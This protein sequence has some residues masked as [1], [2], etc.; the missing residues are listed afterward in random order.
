MK[1]FF[2]RR[3]VPA[4]AALACIAGL[5][6]TARAAGDPALVAR[7]AYLAT[8]ADCVAC[9]TVP[10]QQ[11]FTGG[12][13]FSLPFGTLYSTNITPDTETG[14]G[15]WTDDDFVRA[16]HEGI[17]KGGVHLYPAFPYASFTGMSREDALAIKA[18]LFSLPPVHSPAPENKIAFPFNL[19]F[20]MAAWNMLYNPDKRFTPDPA[21]SAEWNRG[22]YLVNVLGHC[23]ECH[24]PRTLAFGLDQ[25]RPLAGTVVDGWK[26]YN[27]TPDKQ[28]GIGGWTDEAL[29]Q[30]LAT[31][32]AEGH[33]VASGPMAEAIED[34]LRHLTPQDIHAMVVYLKSVPPQPGG[35]GP[36]V[37]TD[38]PALAQTV[39]FGP[40]PAAS[41][42]DLGRHIFE[43]SCASCHSWDGTGLQTPYAGLRGDR[44][45]NDP[46]ATNVVQIVLQGANLHTAAGVV[47]MPSFANA[48]TDAEIAAVANYVVGRFGGTPA[49]VT[50]A[51]VARA[52]AGTPPPPWLP[53]VLPAIV[54]A[55][56]L[57]LLAVVLALTPRRRIA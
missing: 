27:I 31:G 29:A 53:Y 3:V 8:A 35:T 57:A 7:G 18:Y 19:R 30:F 50:A 51:D 39:A 34:S 5:A 52:R 46:D 4:F 13:A 54:L 11:R 12:R 22:S 47:T 36:V 1:R 44:S 25:S 33:G 28:S 14:I 9:H 2:A 38:P 45:V 10:G 6:S 20:G 23:A 15:S 48:Y 37:N 49:T 56:L 42:P 55:V 41:G 40:G 24:T 17:G 16:L 21:Q 26:A 43:G 32:H